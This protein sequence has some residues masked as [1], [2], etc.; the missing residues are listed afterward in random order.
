VVVPDGAGLL[1]GGNLRW[2]RAT[3]VTATLVLPDIASPDQIVYAI[4][5]VMTSDG[6]VLQAAAGASPNRT[7]WAGFAWSVT[8]ADSESP[9]YAWVLNASEPEMSPR[10][11]VSISIFYSPGGWSLRI[12]DLDTQASL[13]SP[14]GPGPAPALRAGDQ[15]AFALESYSRTPATFQAMGNLTVRSIQIDGK[16]VASGCYFYGDWDMVHNPLFVVGSS[17]TSPPSFI[18][19]AAGSGGSFS[20]EYVGFWEVQGDPTSGLEV[21]AF[22]AL[23]G[24]AV[25]GSLGVWLA[26]KSRRERDHS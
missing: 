3:N 18:S 12:T 20:W 19:A 22:A 15:E 11:N 17:G 24:A 26:R 5:S 23:A 21:I 4:L 9:T 1:G 16:V 14:F 7:G 13:E 2:E 8:G 6:T 10:A 25:L